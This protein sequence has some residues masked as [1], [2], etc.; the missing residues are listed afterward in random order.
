MWYRVSRWS[1]I[2]CTLELRATLGNLR[3][4]SH[5]PLS[6]S[7]TRDTH[8]RGGGITRWFSV[9]SVCRGE[10]ERHTETHET[11]PRASRFFSSLPPRI[12]MRRSSFSFSCGCLRGVKEARPA[13]HVTAV[14]LA[15]RGARASATRRKKSEVAEDVPFKARKRRWD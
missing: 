6:T 1:F 8:S 12:V 2:E 9:S 3:A 15:S 5:D 7:G 10:P 14:T 4:F 11:L 13:R